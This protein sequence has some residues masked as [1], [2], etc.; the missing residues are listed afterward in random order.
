MFL[1]MAPSSVS[2]SENN[3]SRVVP[4]LIDIAI[5]HTLFN[6]LFRA[7]NSNRMLRFLVSYMF[8]MANTPNPMAALWE[9]VLLMIGLAV[10]KR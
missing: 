2:N 8:A 9:T 3:Q 4:R 6:A 10:M 1:N 7:A 5:D